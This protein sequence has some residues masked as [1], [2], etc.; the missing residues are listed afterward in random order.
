MVLMGGICGWMFS[1]VQIDPDALLQVLSHYCG[2]NQ[3]RGL[4][5]T[6]QNTLEGVSVLLMH[7][8]RPILCDIRHG[9]G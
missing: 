4:D 2:R 1:V 5:L 8:D 3:G 6:A 7:H 9:A